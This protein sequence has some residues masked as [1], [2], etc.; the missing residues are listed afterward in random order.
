LALRRQKI[1]GV[2]TPLILPAFYYPI[3]EDQ[4]S[5]GLL[6]PSLGYSTA[7]GFTIDFYAER[8]AIDYVRGLETQ[9]ALP[10]LP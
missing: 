2:P 10:R 8:R 9:G 4:R 1:K 3:Q 5:T 6:F 7:L